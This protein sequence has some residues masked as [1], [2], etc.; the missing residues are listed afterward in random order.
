MIQLLI[1]LITPFVAYI[2]AEQLK[3]SGVLATVVTGA[4]LGTRTEGPL[5][6]KDAGLSGPPPH[7]GRCRRRAS[8][9]SVTADVAEAVGATVDDYACCLSVSR[10]ASRCCSSMC[11]NW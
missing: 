5:Q 4:Y 2:P 6:P 1:T 10:L 8:Y 3:V 9:S 7:G 11:R